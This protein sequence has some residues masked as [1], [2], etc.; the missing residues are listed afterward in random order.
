MAL[1]FHVPTSNIPVGG[2]DEYTKL[3]LH[4]DG[5]DDGTVFTDDSESNHTV[6]RVNALTKTGTKKFGTASGYFNGTTSILTIPDSS[7]FDLGT[8]DFTVDFWINFEGLPSSFYSGI[9]GQRANWDD[10]CSIAMQWTDITS[11]RINIGLNNYSVNVDHEWTPSL[12]T[13]YHIALVRSSDTLYLFI[14]GQLGDSWDVTGLDVLDSTELFTIGGMYAV[15]ESESIPYYFLEG[16][17]DEF[18]FSSGIA[19]WTSNFTP[20]TGPYTE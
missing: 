10:Q 19:R 2:I 4:M 9:F 16:N 14:D 5:V 3:M 17:I 11:N 6:T 12:G 1:T 15:P 18:R 20:E 8:N 7:D 13:W